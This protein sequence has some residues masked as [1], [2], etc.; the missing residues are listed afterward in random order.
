MNHMLRAVTLCA[1]AGVACSNVNDETV[2][3]ALPPPLKAPATLPGAAVSL[4]TAAVDKRTQLRDRIAN[5]TG[6]AGAKVIAS[7]DIVE[8]VRQAVEQEF[9]AEGFALGGGGLAV[10]VEVENFYG[11]Y[12]GSGAAYTSGDTNV[13]AKVAFTLRVRDRAGATVAVG[14]YEGTANVRPQFLTQSAE[15]AK[16]ALEQALGEAVMRLRNDHAFRSKLLTTASK[17]RS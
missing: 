4:S 1:A 9:Q 6:L 14:H 13:V 10:A 17:S 7:N 11:L 5:K 3:I 15:A 16:A 8:V 12:G 2:A